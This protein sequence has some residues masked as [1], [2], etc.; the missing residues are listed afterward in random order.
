MWRKKENGGWLLSGSSRPSSILPPDGADGKGTDAP[1]LCEAAKFWSFRLSTPLMNFQC[2]LAR[3]HSCKLEK[4]KNYRI[5]AIFLLSPDQVEMQRTWEKERDGN[6]CFFFLHIMSSLRHP[7]HK[8]ELDQTEE[9]NESITSEESCC[10][11][12]SSW[13]FF[14]FLIQ[15]RWYYTRQSGDSVQ[16][17]LASSSSLTGNLLTWVIYESSRKLDLWNMALPVWDGRKF[18]GD[19]EHLTSANLVR[20]ATLTLSLS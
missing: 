5:S 4:R 10:C 15:E 6:F 19:S 13:P 18:I 1:P 16:Q 2:P 12:S 11:C 3:P 17:L 20:R 7:P 9:G 8:T 14:S